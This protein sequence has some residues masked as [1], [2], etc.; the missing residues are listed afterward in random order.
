MQ[1]WCKFCAKI[2]LGKQFLEEVQLDPLCTKVSQ[3]YCTLC[4]YVL[5]KNQGDIRYF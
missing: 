5:M 2:P 3:K 1:I 4:T